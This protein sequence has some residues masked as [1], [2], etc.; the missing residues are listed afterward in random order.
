MNKEQISAALVVD[1]YGGTAGL[2]TMEDIMEEVLGDFNDEH[3]EVDQHY[4]KINDNIY[5]FQGRYDLESV[6]DVLGISFDEETDQVT[7]GGYVFNL[8]GRLPVVGDKIED[9]NCYYEVRKMDGA[10]ISRVKVR[11]KIKDDEENVQA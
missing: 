6:E 11:K 5:E 10:S 4:K 2:L 1:E 8:I 7:I 3:D 9:E